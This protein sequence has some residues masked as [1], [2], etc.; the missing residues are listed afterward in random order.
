MLLNGLRSVGVAGA[1]LVIAACGYDDSKTDG[2]LCTLS[3]VNYCE[4]N[5]ATN[6]ISATDGGTST[7]TDGGTSTYRWK[8]TD[9]AQGCFVNAGLAACAGP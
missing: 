3:Q 2:D 1:L 7:P 5:A 9:C 8:Q 4:G 6:C